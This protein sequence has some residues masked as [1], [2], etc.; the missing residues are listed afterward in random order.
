MD[1]EDLVIGFTGAPLYG[2]KAR[3]VDWAEGGYTATD[4]PNPRGELHI[5]GDSVSKGY[6]AQ[7]ELTQEAFYVEKGV[8]WFRTGD[9]AEVNPLGMFRIID[10]KKDLVKLQNGEYVSLGRVSSARHVTSA[11]TLMN[12][13][14]CPNCHSHDQH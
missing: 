3:L 14:K 7:E 2:I 6:F 12:T 1:L 5:G 11:L 10:R 4:R 13:L 8:Q 9:I